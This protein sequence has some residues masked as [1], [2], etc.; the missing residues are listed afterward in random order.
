MIRRVS[1]IASAAALMTVLLLPAAAPA[2]IKPGG[3]MS[4]NVTWV[5]TIP[6]DSPGIGGRVVDLGTQKRFYVTGVKGLSIYDVTNPGLP[7]L[8]GA[9]AIPHWENEDVVVSDDGNRVIISTDIFGPTYVLDTTIPAAPLVAQVLGIGSHTVTCVDSA[10]DWIY[11]SEGDIYDLRNLSAPRFL[12]TSVGQGWEAKAESQI[13]AQLQQTGHDLNQDDAGYVITDTMPRLMLD[14]SNPE[15]PVVEAKSAASV[16]GGIAYQHN[17]IRPDASAWTPRNTSTPYQP[18]ETLNPGEILYANGETNFTRTCNNSTNG[19][20]ATWSL[21]NWDQGQ[22]IKLIDVFRPT[23]GTYLNGNPAVNVMG[24]SGHW[25]TVRNGLVAAGWYDHG[26]RFL[27]VDATGQITEVGFFQPVVGEAS[28]AHWVDDEYVYV[29]DYARGIDILRFDRS[30]AP[31][32]QAEIDASWLAKI[33]NLP[34][35]AVAAEQFS[36]RLAQQN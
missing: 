20:F 8:L 10:C 30:A 35:A 4:S 15:F 34:S 17:N 22:E 16:G 21:K 13:G 3:I 31:P 19:P 1:L 24:C 2:D 27:D 5:A 33:G 12:L 29:V 26:T 23:G 6:L 14:V 28:A 7:L 11:S 18:G 32:S 25:F 9:I 36:C